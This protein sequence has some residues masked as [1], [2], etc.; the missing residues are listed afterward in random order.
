MDGS[1]RVP[2]DLTS[3]SSQLSLSREAF[4]ATGTSMTTA[5]GAE[6]IIL[7]APVD[8]SKITIPLSLVVGQD[9]VDF[10]AL[11]RCLVSLT[12]DADRETWA[13]PRLCV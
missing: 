5:I 7:A 13:P 10:V 9:G 4:T 8:N 2:A 1:N 3:N 12:A 11:E 6:Q